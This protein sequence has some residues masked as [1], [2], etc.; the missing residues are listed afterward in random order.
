[1]LGQL[2]ALAHE[3]NQPLAA[4]LSNADAARYLLE[5]DPLDVAEL[6]EIIRD[7]AGEDRRAGEII[8]RLRAFYQR[9]EIRL[10]TV[11]AKDL[12]HE[13]LELAHTELITRRVVPTASLEPDLPP[14]RGDRVQLQQVLLNLILNG[15]EA[16]S[17]NADTDRPLS[18]SVRSDV[19]SVHFAVRDRGTGIPPALLEHLFEPF[20]TTKAEGLGLGLSISRTIITAHGGRIWA[21]NNADRGATMHCLLPVPPTP[22]PDPPLI[23]EQA[24]GC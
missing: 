19:G 23:R 15:C 13:V 7:I 2:G 4:I 11:H 16:M 8:K 9:G 22:S 10:Q 1:M 21:E 18:L 20:V 6:R 3:L 24:R 5:R 17:A 14:V 12:V